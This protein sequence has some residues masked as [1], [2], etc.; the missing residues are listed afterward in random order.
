MSGD[1]VEL[2]VDNTGIALYN[3]GSLPIPDSLLEL[4]R[5]RVIDRYP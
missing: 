1:L 2:A 4:L 5:K 3:F